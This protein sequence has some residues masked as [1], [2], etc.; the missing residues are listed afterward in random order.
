MLERAWSYRRTSAAWR[1]VLV[2][3]N[4]QGL[5]ALM[6]FSGGRCIGSPAASTVSWGPCQN[7]HCSRTFCNHYNTCDCLACQQASRV[8]LLV[9]EARRITQV[10]FQHVKGHSGNLSQAARKGVKIG[11]TAP[12]RR[13][14][15]RWSCPGSGTA[16]THG[17]SPYT[18]HFQ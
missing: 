17:P 10:T 5:D 6:G 8:A 11:A 16:R 7:H 13:L 18:Q 15:R 4:S 14:P 1:E 3:K 12:C 2:Q 9:D